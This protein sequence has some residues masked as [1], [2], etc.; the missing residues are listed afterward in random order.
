MAESGRLS[1]TEDRGAAV[2]AGH[3]WAH[4]IPSG[5]AAPEASM[6]LLLGVLVSEKGCLLVPIWLLYQFLN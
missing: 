5:T 6:V 1:S 2:L 4:A 3:A